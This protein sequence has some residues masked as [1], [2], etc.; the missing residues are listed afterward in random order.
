MEGDTSVVGSGV[1]AHMEG[2][3]SV[4]TGAEQLTNFLGLLMDMMGNMCMRLKVCIIVVTQKYVLKD[5]KYKIRLHVS[6][7]VPI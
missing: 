6:L 2:E 5:A 4:V 1:N 7:N 3:T